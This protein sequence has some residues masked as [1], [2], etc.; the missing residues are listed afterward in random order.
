MKAS[1]SAVSFAAPS[2]PVLRDSRSERLLQSP[3]HPLVLARGDPSPRQEQ[4]LTRELALEVVV[5]EKTRLA[6]NLYAARE[7]ARQDRENARTM[8]RRANDA[9]RKN[10]E[11]LSEMRLEVTKSLR[12]QREAH[13]EAVAK[14]RLE[15]LD[16]LH[17]MRE[18]YAQRLVDVTAQ[19]VER[20]VAT[21]SMTLAFGEWH[22]KHWIT[23]RRRRL[24]Q[25]T[26]RARAALTL[27]VLGRALMYWRHVW[28]I[29]L[30]RRLHRAEAHAHALAAS[31]EDASRANEAKLLG[32]RAELRNW[33]ERLAHE[34][35]VQEKASAAAQLE[36]GEYERAA[37]RAR[38]KYEQAAE[39][40]LLA[41][42]HSIDEITARSRRDH[43][44]ITTRSPACGEIRV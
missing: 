6:A 16:T 31:A 22:A 32:V 38:E 5:S 9:R 28:E 17:E 18:A 34:K 12:V 3:R 44:E 43:D 33:E 20:R 2:P 39:R 4:L 14:L 36:R 15:E 7:E 30:Q 37:E 13:E 29:A 27:R 23:V 10:E 24:V 41:L 11:T 40:E 21:N 35:A 42:Q 8:E 1:A 19:L 26:H 25:H